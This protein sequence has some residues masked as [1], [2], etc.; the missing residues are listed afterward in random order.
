MLC[1]ELSAGGEANGQAMLQSEIAGCAAAD[2]SKKMQF[3]REFN[4][5]SERL[6]TC[7]WHRFPISSGMLFRRLVALMPMISLLAMWVPSSAAQSAPSPRMPQ[8]INVSSYDPKE[9]QRGGQSFSEHDVS[10]LRANGA[11]GLIARC[12]KGGVLDTKCANF[13]AAADR[14]GMLIGTYY[15]LQTHVDAVAQADQYVNRMQAIARSRGW[16]N[17]RI[18]LCGDFDAKSRLSDFTRFLARVES[19]TGIAPVVYLENSDHLKRLLSTADPA[20]KARLKRSPFWVALYSHTSGGVYGVAGS[21]AGLTKQYN[22]W[23]NW[24]LWQYG[25]VDWSRGRSCP[26]SYSFGGFKSSP[27]FGKLDRPCERNVFNGN[28]SELNAFWARHGMA[29]K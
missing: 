23:N 20:T 2:L 19:R 3:G 11:V 5:R 27:Y 6:H 18:L 14:E 22:V 13:L 12:G 1:G 21:P 10:A 9:K 25:G 24:S 8:I 28:R 17:N 7:P 16:K 4:P 29:V 26:K 15:R